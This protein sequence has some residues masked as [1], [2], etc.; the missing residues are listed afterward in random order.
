MDAQK[1]TKRTDINP[2]R[3]QEKLKQPEERGQDVPLKKPTFKARIVSPRR[4]ISSNAV[5]AV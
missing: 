2:E 4:K 3:Y 1:Q 5:S